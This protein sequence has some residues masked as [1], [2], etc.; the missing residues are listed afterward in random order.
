MQVKRSLFF[1]I[2][3]LFC[4][5]SLYAVKSWEFRI[6]RTDSINYQDI[7]QNLIDSVSLDNRQRIEDLSQKDWQPN[8]SH[9][10]LWAILPGG[11]QIYNRKYWKV[12]LVWG[13]F[14]TSYYTIIWNHGM[15]QE[16][17]AAYRDLKSQDPSKNTAWL[18]FAPKGTKAQDYKQHLSLTS[19]LK[20]GNDF[21]RRNRDFSII[22]G[23]LI[24]GLSFIDAYVDA[25]LSTFD[26][27]PDLSLRVSPCLLNDPLQESN[28]NMGLACSIIF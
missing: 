11:G 7:N 17:H 16:Y 4:I 2:T 5:Q 21:Y 9:A 3:I 20:R 10:L 15:Y 25:E 27:S 28:C 12:P 14:M 26:I 6:L 24:Y 18:P 19:R 13:A 8:S 1:L 22:V 23:I